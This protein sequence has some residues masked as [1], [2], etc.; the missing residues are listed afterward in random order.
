VGPPEKLRSLA[1][2]G[3]NCGPRFQLFAHHHHS[4][5]RPSILYRNNGRPVRALPQ[6]RKPETT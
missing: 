4:S 6:A 3:F 2:L 1:S 5:A